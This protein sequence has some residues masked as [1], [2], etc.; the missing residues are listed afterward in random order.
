MLVTLA[1]CLN[2]EM[3]MNRHQAL[4]VKRKTT[5]LRSML[6]LGL[7]LS[8]CATSGMVWAQNTMYGDANSGTSSNAAGPSNISQTPPG[9]GTYDPSTNLVGVPPFQQPSIV[10]SNPG[11]NM[12]GTNMS[13]TNMNN[14][15]DD[16][17]SPSKG[18]NGGVAA[19]TNNGNSNTPVL[20]ET[21]PTAAEQGLTAHISPD[22]L[23][24]QAQQWESAHTS[25]QQGQREFNAPPLNP[26]AHVPTLTGW[27]ANWEQVLMQEG[28][29]RE[30]IH[31]EAS[32][33]DHKAFAKW[34]SNVLRYHRGP[35][36]LQAEEN[37]KPL[38]D[39]GV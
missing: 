30:K 24:Y 26:V 5:S 17:A 19:K 36:P 27:L 16:G 9:Y 1:L 31:F 4:K 3:F 20:K 2:Q 29:S 11:S 6:Y 25:R 34:A 32:R 14:P 10:P 23:A 39:P 35:H 15:N 13:G 21:T 37:A 12:S 38:M 28:V 8:L 18:Q 7:S 22:E 33:L